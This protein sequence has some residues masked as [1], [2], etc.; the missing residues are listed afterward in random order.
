[1]KSF[2]KV[3][4]AIT[5]LLSTT[6]SFAQ[7]KNA[8]IETVTVN[9]NCG[10]CKKVIEKAANSNNLSHVIW[11]V[12]SKVATITYDETK[13]NLDTVLEKIALSGYESNKHLASDKA[14]NKLP[15]CCQYERNT[16]VEGSK[17]SK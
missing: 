3:M 4:I 15:V 13:T 11:D 16:M 17:V 14:Y 7:I 9:G 5:L 1:M 2:L 8:K 6:I 12:E 10:M